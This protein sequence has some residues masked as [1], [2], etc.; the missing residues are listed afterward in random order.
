MK[1]KY[2]FRETAVRKRVQSDVFRLDSRKQFYLF[3]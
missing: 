1:K 3:V 2:I